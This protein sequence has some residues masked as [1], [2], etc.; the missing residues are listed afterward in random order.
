MKAPTSAPSR[1]ATSCCP[2]LLHG[3]SGRWMPE[4]DRADRNGQPPELD[5]GRMYLFG[6]R[7]GRS[8]SEQLCSHTLSASQSAA[9]P[10]TESDYYHIPQVSASSRRKS[11]VNRYIKTFYTHA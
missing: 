6:L 4:A 7:A 2:S 9:P 3:D 11:R 10:V 1:T 5:E 8:L